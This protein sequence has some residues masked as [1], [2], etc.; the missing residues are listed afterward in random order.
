ME[1]LRPERKLIA[2]NVTKAFMFLQYRP[3]E[4]LAKHR[5]S[6]S[7]IVAKVLNNHIASSLTLVGTQSEH[8]GDIRCSASNLLDVRLLFCFCA[9]LA[10]RT[11]DFVLARLCALSQCRVNR[12]K[13]MTQSSSRSFRSFCSR[14]VNSTPHTQQRSTTCFF[15]AVFHPF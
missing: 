2:E 6:I 8:S 13:D 4:S 3:T 14:P 5:V 1:A 7:P 10:P 9:V 11:D 12:L 15:L